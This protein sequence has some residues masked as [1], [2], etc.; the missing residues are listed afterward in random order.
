VLGRGEADLG[1]WGDQAA[2]GDIERKLI[3]T[4][5]LRQVDIRLGGKAGVSEFLCVR[6]V[7]SHPALGKLL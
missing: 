6:L 5:R 4:G 7:R 2:C 1:L 3:E